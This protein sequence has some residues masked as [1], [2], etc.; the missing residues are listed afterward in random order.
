MQAVIRRR[1]SMARRVLAFERANP[2]SDPSHQSVVAR[3]ADI[4]G[5]FDLVLPRRHQGIAAEHSAVVRRREKRRALRD[6]L[7]H[8]VAVA[9]VAA[10]T[11]I[12]L[13]EKFRPREYYGPNREFVVVARAMLADATLH[14]EAL[15]SCGLGSDFFDD[16]S[17][18][19]GEFE[20]ASVEAEE[21][22]REHV[23]A[24]ADSGMLGREITAHVRILDGLNLRRLAREPGLAAAWHSARNVYG[25]VHH[26]A[27]EGETPDTA[28]QGTEQTRAA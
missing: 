7:R 9:A 13:L 19:I 16:L 15:V 20:A 4:I 1:L 28:E 11:D 5:R 6:R 8:L 24:S 21:G 23:T 10:E 17:N 2:A 25:P 26:G 3:L 27:S 14:A 22:R 12:T 18:A